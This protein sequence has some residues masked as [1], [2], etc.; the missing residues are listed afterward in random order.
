LQLK[1]IQQQGTEGRGLTTD[2]NTDKTFGQTTY[3]TK[4]TK[5]LKYSK[6]APRKKL[7]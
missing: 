2:H 4:E 3:T 7:V 5:L 6:T 1:Q